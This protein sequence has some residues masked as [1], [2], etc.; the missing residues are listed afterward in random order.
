MVSTS[1]G[2]SPT[3]FSTTRRTTR[4]EPSRAARARVGALIALQVT[5]LARAKQEVRAGQFAAAEMTFDEVVEITRLIG[6]HLSSTSL[7][8]IDV[9]AWRGHESQT[10]AAAKRLRELAVANSHCR[11]HQWR[12][13]FGRNART[14]SRPVPTGARPRSNR[15]STTHR[16]GIRASRSRSRSRP[17][18]AP[19]NPT[20]AARYLDDLQQRAA[21]SGTDW[22]SGNSPA[23]VRSW[24]TTPT[25]RTCISKRSHDSSRRRS[26]QNWH[27]PGSSTASGS[28][29][30]SDR[31]TRG[32]RSEPP[33][34][35]SRDGRGGLRRACAFRAR[36]DR[37]EGPS[38][39]GRARHR[40]H[41]QEAQAA[42]LAA[43]GATNPE[44]AAR[45]FISTNTVDYHLRKVYRKLG[46][47][48]R[49]YLA[50]AIPPLD[51]PV[52]A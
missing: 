37:G 1:A 48:S 40:P 4:G 30:K 50:N 35:R 29:A 20:G 23:A 22:L 19:A 25:P 13:Y 9:Y 24:P 39:R 36:R 11:G 21:A 17:R 16:R 52:D 38:S 10:H 18:P 8:K 43:A 33:T 12:G 34:T 6:G 44:I 26:P 47:S 3:N 27:K 31:S 41:P 14:R 5:L 7:L 2:W 15:S 28:G 32:S 46:I 42:R 49:R 45:M 51:S